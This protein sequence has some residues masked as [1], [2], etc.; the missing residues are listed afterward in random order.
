MSLLSR[1]LQPHLLEVKSIAEVFSPNLKKLWLKKYIDEEEKK[2]IFINQVDASRK[3]DLNGVRKVA[4]TID[5]NEF[6]TYTKIKN[7]KISYSNISF[8][9]GAARD[10]VLEKVQQATF[11]VAKGAAWAHV[12]MEYFSEEEYLSYAGSE[13]NLYTKDGKLTVKNQAG[14]YAYNRTKGALITLVRRGKD[15]AAN[16]LKLTGHLP[17]ISEKTSIKSKKFTF[18]EDTSNFSVS[19]HRADFIDK[20][21]SIYSVAKDQFYISDL[22]DYK[23]RNVVVFVEEA[24]FAEDVAK[25]NDPAPIKNQPKN[26]QNQTT[27]ASGNSKLLNGSE[28]PKNSSKATIDADAQVQ[29][30][31]QASK[32][33]KRLVYYLNRDTGE[34]SAIDRQFAKP[35]VYLPE[36]SGEKLPN[37]EQKQKHLENS[38]LASY[39]NVF[40]SSHKNNR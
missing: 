4:D 8:F 40:Y 1:A 15:L 6:H 11:G 2:L 26:L 13:T 38:S 33:K 18:N 39:F 30:Q 34:L 3:K 14:I 37:E 35:R 16:S 12:T 7:A 27:S 21:Q 24:F 20:N 29:E 5:W 10:F 22:K 28:K 32:R 25:K 9:N 36:G 17:K 19:Q 23:G 31:K